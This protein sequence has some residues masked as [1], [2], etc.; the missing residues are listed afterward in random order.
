VPSI[1]AIGLRAEIVQDRFGP[2]AARVRGQLEHRAQAVRSA[3]E[4]RAEEIPGGAGDQT[5]SWVGPVLAVE[6]DKGGEGVAAS[7]VIYEFEY[8]AVIGRTTIHRRAEQ[9]PGSVESQLANR[10]GPA[11]DAIEAGQRSQRVAACAIVYEL[12]HR[13]IAV[14]AALRCRAE[15]VPHGIGDHTALWFRSARGAKRDDVGERGVLLRPLLVTSN[16]VPCAP[17]A[18]P[19]ASVVPNRLPA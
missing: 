11:A 7:A 9:I 17:I 5:A 10:L 1:H 6:A 4:C 2:T 15:E 18:L 13:A 8:R 16:T 12:E 14:R 19:P 3:I